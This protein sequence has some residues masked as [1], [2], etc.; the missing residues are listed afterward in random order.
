M[1]E[2]VILDVGET[3]PLGG[4]LGGIEPELVRWVSRH[5]DVVRVDADG[6]ATGVSEGWT[7]VTAVYDGRTAQCAV[8][9]LDPANYIRVRRFDGSTTQQA[10]ETALKDAGVSYTKKWVESTIAAGHISELLFTGYRDS[11]YYYISPNEPVELWISADAENTKEPEKEPEKQEPAKKESLSVSV[12]PD[13]RTFYSGD[14]LTTSGLKLQYT[15]KTGKTQTVSSGFQTTA[16]MQAAGTKQVTVTYKGLTTSYSITVKKPSVKLQKEQIEGGI[17]LSATTDPA[18]QTVQWI[19]LNPQIAYFEGSELR[20]AGAGTATIK[21]SMVYNGVTYSDTTT[22]TVLAEEK[23]NYSFEIRRTE[24]STNGQFYKYFVNTNIPNFDS[25]KVTWWLEPVDE[26]WYTEGGCAYLSYGITARLP[27][28]T[29][30]TEK[31]IRPAVIRRLPSRITFSTSSLWSGRRA[32][33]PTRSRR[34]SPAV[35]PARQHGRSC[36]RTEAAGSTEVNILSMNSAWKT[37]RAIPSRSATPIMERLILRPVPIR[38]RSSQAQTCFRSSRTRSR[39]SSPD[40]RR[41]L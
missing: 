33:R 4:Q 28:H 22:I 14:T 16:N 3:V 8:W 29:S 36:L 30:T 27:R 38:T 13:K 31:P 32:A 10:A 9:V 19:S 20:A 21:A 18:G 39:R 15:D 41:L 12:L 11:D 2:L 35:R 37:A 1:S 17:R 23:E 40:A 26:R 7:Y 34:I 25:S 6:M 5:P 24:T